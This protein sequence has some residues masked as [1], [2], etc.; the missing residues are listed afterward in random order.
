M[1]KILFSILTLSFI[2]ASSWQSINSA[3][4][5]KTNLVAESE[6]LNKTLVSFNIEGFN[7]NPVDVDGTQMFKAQLIDG[8]SLLL[9]GAPDLHKYAKSIVIP[10][11]KKMSFKIISSD[12]IDYENISIAPSKGNLSR[13][14]DPS[15]IP[16]EF[17]GVYLK[18]SFYPGNI[19][20]IETPYILRDL[21][22]QSIVFYPFQYNPVTKLLR[23]YNTIEVEVYSD[24]PAINNVLTQKSKKNTRQKEFNNIYTNHFINYSPDSRFDYL[25]DHG[26]LL[27]ISY[28]TFMTTMQPLVDWKTFKGIPTE[29]VNVSDIGTSATAISNYV[30]NYYYENGLTFLLLVGD[31]AQIPS[32]TVSGSASD[33][34][35]GF[36][37]GNDFYSEIIVG[38]FSGSTPNQIATQVERSIS[39]ERYPQAGA[40][41]YDN[42]L[43]VASAEGPGFGGYSDD[44]FNEFLWNTVLSDFTYDSYQGIYDGSGGSAS[45]GINAINSGVGIINYTGHGSISSWGN[46]AP[47]SS[48]NVNSLT[49][50]NRLP[51]VI[52]VGCNVGEFN[53]TNECYAESWLRATNNGEPAGGISHFG[54]TIPQSWEPPMHGQYGMNLILTESLDQNLTRTMG[55]ITSNG[56]MY[57]NDAQGSSGINETKFWTYFGDPTVPLRTAPPVEIN[58]VYEDVI[59]LG[60][61]NY[62]VTTGT[63]GDLVALSKN[64]VLL[65]SGYTDRFGSVSLS[66]GESSQTPGEIDLVI[67]GFNYVPLE[68]TVMVLSPD[69]PYLSAGNATVLSGT[70]NVIE[71]G[72]TVQLSMILENIGSDPAINVN[73]SIST[74]D[75]L[76]SITNS[77]SGSSTSIDPDGSILIDGLEFEVSGDIPNNYNFDIDCNMSDNSNNNWTASLSFIAYAPELSVDAV[78][79]D[80]DPGQ[81]VDLS[82]IITNIGGTQITYPFV[83]VQSDQYVTINSSSFSNAYS[84][85][86]DMDASLDLNVSVS[87]N[88]PI[89]HLATFDVAIVANLGDGPI[90]NTSFDIPIGQVTAN[91]E[92]GLGSLEWDLSCDGLG[93][94]NWDLDNSNSSSGSNSF[95]S[96]T[97]G[98]NQR[99]DFSVTLDVTADGQIEFD[100]RVEAEYSTSG[101]YFY[102]G[103]EFY[104]DNTLQGQYQTLSGGDSPWT[105]VSYN[106]LAGERT[107]R[108][109]FVK[110]GGGGSTDCVNTNCEDAAW[111][112]EIIFPPA[113]MESDA[114]VGD[115]NNDGIINILDVISMIN[116]ILEIDQYSSMA[117]LNTDGIIN[118]LDVVQ[119][120]NLILGP[121][122]DNASKIELFDDGKNIN[123]VTNGYVGAIKMILSHGS[124]FSI[125]L[126]QD[127]F[128]PYAHYE[129]N[130]TT[131]FIINPQS[132]HLFH[133]TGDFKI[134]EFEA[135][136]S[137]NYIE[138]I[139][140]Q[141]THL[142]E[143]YPNPFNPSTN[144]GFTL[145]KDSN[146]NLSIFNIHGQLVETLI[147][148]KV[149]AGSYNLKWDA[150]SQSSGMYFLRLESDK[151]LYSQKLMV[152]K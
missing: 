9:K 131:V 30:D 114:L 5:K 93:C 139:L 73:V 3:I 142:N 129:N 95:K 124:D 27:I 97:I 6:S 126:N 152:V 90:T 120:I 4:E 13:D 20:R 11:D 2:T 99:S 17:S 72:E 79:G 38:R 67:T 18:N 68:S 19:V 75:D 46:G 8:A 80:L 43:G 119:E 144:I 137:I 82:A 88:A 47:I 87:P 149:S 28:G 100:Y 111:V 106:V 89:G 121:R 58:A 85:E 15:S 61:N 35:Y 86:V 117:D 64:G 83:V 29:M 101:N 66:L 44:D 16:H 74:D 104:I 71:Y 37:A 125:S 136:N 77:S 135:A 45:Q 134:L 140:P 51:F 76:I 57:M 109:S 132:N 42:A 32:P 148:N 69:G 10:D 107:F 12:Y 7:L 141:K 112:D 48:S 145:S 60:S 62:T 70:D 147:S 33:P 81:T 102:D 78:L 41:W 133:Y 53:N 65:A 113:Y 110:D 138:S 146:I 40:S 22:G 34:S 36:I 24:G 25:E 91:F 94:L 31:I 128:L 96:G 23:V 116:I 55:G 127:A 150:S 52:T 118:I 105:N 130:V 39:Y 26:N 49:N 14:V 84:L 151:V 1:Y 103:L 59:I 21:R 115:L 63:E 123:M 122:F 92:E 143:A 50:N 108:W 54:S 56:C 98:D